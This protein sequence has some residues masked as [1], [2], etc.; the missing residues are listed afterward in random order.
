[1]LH[2][3]ISDAIHSDQ[4]LMLLGTLL[5]G[6][7]TLFKSTNLYARMR[8]RRCERALLALETG[9]MNTYETYVREIKAS[10]MDGRLT[11]DE[12]REARRRAKSYAIDIAQTDGLD[13][14]RDLGHH[15][16]DAWIERLVRRFKR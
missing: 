4:G 1:M 8:R 10:R 6:I 12:R 5:G 2:M 7:W 13:I 15:Y 3:N 16:L 9:V 14:A 11:A